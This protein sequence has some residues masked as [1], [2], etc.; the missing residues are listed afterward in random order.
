[1]IGGS[2]GAHADKK[3]LESDEL[4]PRSVCQVLPPVIALVDPWWTLR[5]VREANTPRGWICE[6]R[7]RP[8]HTGAVEGLRR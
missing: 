6:V 4:K 3:S 1:V 5:D 8:D 2:A 7:V